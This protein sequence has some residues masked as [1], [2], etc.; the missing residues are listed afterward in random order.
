MIVCV[1]EAMGIIKAQLADRVAGIIMSFGSIAMAIAPVARM[2]NIKFVIAVFDVN[3][4]INVTAIATKAIRASGR[5]IGQ[6]TK[7]EY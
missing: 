4:V 6:F 5:G 3:S 2:G 7:E 1:G